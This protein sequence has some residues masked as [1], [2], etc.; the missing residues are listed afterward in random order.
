VNNQIVLFLKHKPVALCKEVSMLDNGDIQIEKITFSC[1]S[2][3]EI[4]TLQKNDMFEICIM[5]FSIEENSKDEEF[6]ITGFG[7]A[8]TLD[9]NVIG[10]NVFLRKYKKEEYNVVG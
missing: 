9:S 7:N 3:R 10:E 8:Y 6:W 4:T 5:P 1:D 2:L